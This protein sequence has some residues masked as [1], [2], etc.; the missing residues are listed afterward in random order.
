MEVVYCT[1]VSAQPR[2]FS[3]HPPLSSRSI[4]SHFLSVHAAYYVGSLAASWCSESCLPTAVSAQQRRFPA[5]LPPLLAVNFLSL[6]L[7]LSVHAAS[8]HH[9][10][11]ASCVVSACVR[12]VCC[13]GVMRWK[14]FTSFV[15]PRASANLAHYHNRRKKCHGSQRAENLLIFDRS[16]HCLVYRVYRVYRAVRSSDQLE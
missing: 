8:P 3:V 5:Q 16:V 2:K 6:P 7:S 1:S 9:E 12:V 14:L 4:P 11:V 13:G 15:T 10:V